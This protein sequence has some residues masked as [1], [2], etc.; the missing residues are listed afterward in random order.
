M[1]V[2]AGGGVHANDFVFAHKNAER[3]ESIGFDVRIFCGEFDISFGDDSIAAVTFAT[4]NGHA[5]DVFAGRKS[6]ARELF[7]G[8]RQLFACGNNLL[9]IAAEGDQIKTFVKDVAAEDDAD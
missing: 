6:K 9:V 7:G 3:D 5:D 8:V 4:G 1:F 2:L